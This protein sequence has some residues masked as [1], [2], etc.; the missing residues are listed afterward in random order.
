M[1][2]EP[3]RSELLRGRSETSNC[4]GAEARPAFPPAGCSTK[5]GPEQLGSIA[6]RVRPCLVDQHDW[7]IVPDWVHAMTLRALQLS[8]FA[9]IR[10][11][12]CQPGRPEFPADLWQSCQGIIRHGPRAQG[13][14]G[15]WSTRQESL[16]RVRAAPGRQLKAEL[17]RTV[18]REAPHHERSSLRSLDSPGRL[19]PTLCTLT[20]CTPA[21]RRCK[22]LSGS[23]KP[24]APKPKLMPATILDGTKIAQEIRSEVAAEVK[25]HDGRR[26]AS[27][28]GGCAGG[29]QPGV[30][31][32]CS[33]QSQSLRRSGSV[34]READS[35]RVRD[36]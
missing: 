17:R 19:S 7:N 36:D 6:S 3:G 31:N 21:V 13:Q 14:C 1:V 2:V 5:L 29:A 20:P 27:R 9:D 32:L 23:P 4:D 28:A 8:G 11:A 24:R 12:A 26:S 18:R 30:G 33:G 16:S 35:A 34:Q 10:A 25:S 15:Q 22:I